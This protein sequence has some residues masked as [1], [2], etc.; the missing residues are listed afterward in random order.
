MSVNELQ[1]LHDIFQFE[2]S[3]E[4]QPTGMG[5]SIQSNGLGTQLERSDIVDNSNVQFTNSSTIDNPAD[6]SISTQTSD[7][8]KTISYGLQEHVQSGS[9]QDESRTMNFPEGLLITPISMLDDFDRVVG[10][11]QEYDQKAFQVIEGSIKVKQAQRKKRKRTDLKPDGSYNEGVQLKVMKKLL[12]ELESTESI[13]N[14]DHLIGQ[15]QRVKARRDNRDCKVTILLSG[16]PEM[17]I[18]IRDA[19]GRAIT[20]T[21]LDNTIVPE[22]VV[23][24]QN[25]SANNPNH[26]PTYWNLLSLLHSGVNYQDAVDLNSLLSLLSHSIAEQTN[27]IKNAYKPRPPKESYTNNSTFFPDRW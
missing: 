5:E 24:L 21:L 8:S 26:V 10:D 18:A 12:T 3:L 23:V 22:H 20:S 27:D 17:E 19:I 7:L 6:H 14:T 13:Y 15:S 1:Q 9:I 25:K 11:D 2:P 4:S 16:M